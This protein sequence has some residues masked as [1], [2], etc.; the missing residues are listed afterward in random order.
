M[1]ECNTVTTP[2]EIN[3]NLARQIDTCER[4]LPYQQ[5]ISSLMY[6]AVLSRPDIAYS[7][8][9]LSQFNN[10][11]N[12]SHWKQ[13]KRVLRYFKQTKNYDL[14]FVKDNEDLE[15]FVDADWGGNSFDRK[16]YTGFCFKLS[17]SAV[18]WE[19]RKQRT[20]ALSSTEAEY[21]ALSEA[22]KEAIY[23][24][25]ILSE[26]TGLN[27]C[28]RLYNDNQSARKLSI[29][30]MFHNR[31]KHIDIRHHFVREAVADNLI[32]IEYLSTND[33]PAD[34]LTKGVSSEKHNRFVNKLGLVSLQ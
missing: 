17:G 6:L 12:E 32:K 31:S 14:K 20:V 9:Y 24:R 23:L 7:V 16:S 18:S 4:D 19:S 27:N 25:N 28:V 10:C 29:N 1:I 11:H 5:L 2:I 8:S 22:S 34:I 30:P 15:S 33:M 21:M 26:I 3:V 13:A